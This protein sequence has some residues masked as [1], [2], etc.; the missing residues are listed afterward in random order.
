[1]RPRLIATLVANLFLIP[2]ALAE[3]QGLTWTGQVSIGL[4]GTKDNAAD[5]SKLNEYRDLS[6]GVVGNLDLRARTDDYHFLG[7]IEN[8]GY[9]DLF[10]DLKGG[11]FGVF[12]YQIYD[13]ELRHN[14]GSGPGARSPYS[15]IGGSVLT[16]PFAPV[17]SPTW[18]PN[19]WN[20]FDHGYDRRDT[21]GMFEVSLNSPFYLR[22]DGNEVARKG[23][24]VFGGAQG[25]SP[26]N[27]FV[28]LPAPI[29]YK[30]RT[31]S[32]EAGYQGQNSHFAAN[33]LY[34]KFENDNSVLNW[35]NGFFSPAAPFNRDTTVLPPDN[36][37][38]RVGL[39]GNI[40]KLPWDSTLAG[41]Y[42]Y[43]K[44]TN[45]VPV[46]GTMLAPNNAVVPAA[47]A[48]VGTFPSTASNSSVFSGEIVHQ[49][50][51]LSF[52]SHPTRE[53]DTRIYYNWAREE[54]NST[55]LVFNPTAASTLRCSGGPCTP[56]LFGYRK[57]NL[58]IEASY[59][60]NRENKLTGGYDY[61]DI[62]RDRVD[63]HS[64]K[65]HK[66]FVEWKNA[67]LDELTARLKYQ[68]LTRDSDWSVAAP[69][70]ADNPTEFWVRRFDL[71]N[72][73][74]NLVKVVLDWSPRPL[75]DFGLEAI[76]KKNDYKATPLGRVDDDRQEIYASVSFGDPKAFRI[77]VFA[78]VEFLE[79]NSTHRVGGTTVANSDPSAPASP[80]APALSTIYTW[81]AKNEDKA[82][83]V[84]VGAD[85]TPLDRLTF[86]GSLIY[87]ETNGS[88][89]FTAQPGALLNPPFLY[90]IN[91]F[92]NT[93]R[94]ALN[95]KGIYT[96][97]RNW[98][99]TGGYAYEKYRY[100]DIGYDNTRYFVPPLST[101]GSYTTGQFAFQP[102][103]A[104]IFY[105]LATY[106]F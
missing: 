61:Y 64:N 39:N 43:S 60:F 59:R 96:I 97:D 53:L 71:A 17:N 86:K 4:R 92:D 93:R 27:G 84:G 83:Q 44:L 73:N 50:F 18:N 88:T 99:V 22:F 23:I 12:K 55:Q 24:N 101:S 28:D 10:I 32:V 78:D 63:F 33:F 2:S 58:G 90:P 16:A 66:F 104:N 105:V 49:T 100:S 98:S 20:T 81:K 46:Q 94:W 85:W 30:T 40:R 65:D 15:G 41:R 87:A 72:L 25:T 54:N 82:W 38:W 80:A 103:T 35:S 77:M 8:L 9:D 1:M 3:G 47:A 56:E 26:G 21:G 69:V 45:D 36:E 70:I 67:S 6:S 75:L 48:N 68:Y 11:K 89:D 74:Q 79:Y 42:T 5:P 19:T 13:N 31:G 57:N 91:N 52:T 62:H 29:D 37:M 106:K 34:S 7:Y 95:M 14:F 51:S 76:Y 102:Y